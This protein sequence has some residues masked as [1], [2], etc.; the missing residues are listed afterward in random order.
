[1]ISAVWNYLSTQVWVCLIHHRWVKSPVG[2]ITLQKGTVKESQDKC[3]IRWG[4]IY[5]DIQVRIQASVHFT[6]FSCN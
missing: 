2:L 6:E 1:M 4:W 3:F 5:S